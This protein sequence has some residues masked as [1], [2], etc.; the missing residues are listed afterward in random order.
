MEW[1]QIGSRRIDRRRSGWR[2]IGLAFA[3]VALVAACA[4]LEWQPLGPRRSAPI[5]GVARA[6]SEECGVCHTDVQGHERIAGYHADCE[7]CHGGGSLHSESEAVADIRFPGND[8]CLLCHA[9]GRDTHLQWGT[10]EHSRAGLY[11]S[12]CHNPHGTA[13]KHL[14]DA[15]RPG[16]RDSRMGRVGS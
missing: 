12:D 3:G 6:G 13:R 9:P 7:S 2:R 14:R 10:G 8:D 11:C 5:A 16:A 4:S 15:R 1:G